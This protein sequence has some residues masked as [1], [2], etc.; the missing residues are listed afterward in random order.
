MI[1]TSRPPTLQSRHAR[2][3]GQQ[4]TL[5]SEQHRETELGRVGQG[6]EKLELVLASNRG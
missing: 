3:Q 5:G 4:Q 1:S 2:G 6:R